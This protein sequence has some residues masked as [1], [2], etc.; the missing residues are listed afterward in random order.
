MTYL[1]FLPAWAEEARCVKADR[2]LFFSHKTKDIAQA[3]N[4]C[5]NCSVLAQCLETALDHQETDGV[6]GGQL[7][8]RGKILASKRD[9]GRPLKNEDPRKHIL[10]A[11]PMPEHL[12]Q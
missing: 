4:I 3:M 9:R 7:F 12:R 6:W 2:N 5:A 8:R 1:N 10:P 11:A